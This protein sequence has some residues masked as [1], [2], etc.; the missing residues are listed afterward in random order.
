MF[1]VVMCLSPA[2]EFFLC[3]IKNDCRPGGMKFENSDAVCLL[4]M[5]HIYLW[6]RIKCVA[7]HIW[8]VSQIN[9][10]CCIFL[11]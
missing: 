5:I 11:S 4:P 8:P 2:V 3:F 1:D 10:A 6:A 7:G 9:C